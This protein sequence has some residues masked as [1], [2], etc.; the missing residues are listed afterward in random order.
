MKL[1]NPQNEAIA[2]PG[3]PP[4][5]LTSLT[6]KRIA[7]LDISKPGGSHFL[8]RLSTILTGRFG[9][10]EIARFTNP[11]FTK[12]APEALFAQLQAFD[13]VIEGLAD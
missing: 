10:A 6:G 11:T 4:A 8:D 9:V 2:R 5:R 7:L 13:A 12:P 1:V 3:T